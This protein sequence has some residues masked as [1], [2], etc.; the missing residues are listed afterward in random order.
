MCRI[1]AYPSTTARCSAG[2]SNRGGAYQGDSG[3]LGPGVCRI[4]DADFYEKAHF[5]KPT[6]RRSI[7]AEC[8][9]FCPSRAMLLSAVNTL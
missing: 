3:P 4:L 7:V 8:N 1:P 9:S 6:W 2:R 5:V